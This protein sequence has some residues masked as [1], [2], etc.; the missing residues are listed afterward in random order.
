MRDAPEVVFPFNPPAPGEAVELAEGVL[1]LRIPLASFRPDHVNVYA[2]DDG[3]GWSVVDTGLDTA[4]TPDVWEGFLAGPLRGKPVRRILLTHYHPDHVGLAGWLVAKGAELWATRTSWVT[5]RM[6]TLDVQERPRAE[7]LAYWRGAGMP[8]DI[9]AER[10]ARRPFNFADCV[11]P[12]PLGFRAIGEGEEIVA[13]GR[14]WRVE[15]GHGHAPDQATFWG[16]GHELVVTGDQVLP[17]ITP[18]LGVYATEPG[19][20]PVG[21]WIASSRRLGGLARPDH[22]ALP[23]HRRPFLGLPV[24]LAELAEHGEAGLD[25]LE[26]FLHAPR[27]AT[28][29]FDVLY[30]RPIGSGEYLLALGEAVGHL[31]RLTRTG[32]AER[33][34]DAAGAWRWRATARD[35]IATD[36]PGASR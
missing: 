30:G 32:R 9:L 33:Q 13:G 35:E 7:T 11:A 19:A 20:D 17:G 12:L 5:A 27:R 22:L 23:G 29:C 10:A 4:T 6:L 24:R 8:D 18:N 15:I 21:D 1:W 28:D 14:R 3:D 31:N 34:R 26:A 2:L 25:R 36:S 16:V